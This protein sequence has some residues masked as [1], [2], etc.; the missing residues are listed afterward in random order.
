VNAGLATVTAAG[1]APLAWVGASPP[2]AWAPADASTIKDE[3]DTFTGATG[4]LSGH[5]PDTGG[6]WTD[7]DFPLRLDGSGKVVAGTGSSGLGYIGVAAPVVGDGDVYVTL[8]VLAT[9]G[10]S[11]WGP[12]VRW[13]GSQGYIT[14][15]FDWFE[16]YWYVGI[17][18]VDLTV[19]GNWAIGAG[20]T[21]AVAIPVTTSR[22]RMRVNV[23]GWDSTI[24]SVKVWD[25]AG[26]EP[27]E[28]AASYGF[29]PVGGLPPSSGKVGL[30]L[31]DGASQTLDDFLV[32]H[33]GPTTTAWVQPFAP[34]A[35]VVATGRAPVPVAGMS[36]S[37][38]SATATAVGNAPTATGMGLTSVSATLA[39]VTAT[40]RAPTPTGMSI[41]SVSPS[42]AT[43]TAAGNTPSSLWVRVWSAAAAATAA[44]N[45]P[46]ITS[47]G[48]KSVSAG[49]ASAAA[50]G[51][52]PLA[53]VSAIANSAMGTG[54]A[55]P[56]TAEGFLM[57]PYFILVGDSALYGATTTTTALG[58]GSVTET[59][60]T[61]AATTLTALTGAA[62][63][64][65]ALTLAT[66]GDVRG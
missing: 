38:G 64:D 55:W 53:W 32:T 59:A 39:T 65:A 31:E 24:V 37:A 12:F 62:S 40:G 3:S 52:S 34:S 13:D 15:V 27:G 4:P 22:V 66:P 49:S 16:G 8:D 61:G 46:S 28:W 44:G 51:R 58:L 29:S 18:A 35:S 47:L 54:V 43:A 26:S 11:N 20:V 60:Q 10:I 14:Q 33:V 6:A 42:A 21:T 9:S 7:G 17:N 5:T 25:A 50:D 56:P 41:A 36:I 2:A 1:I 57:G 19:D 45:A 23:E 48:L 63:T 30:L